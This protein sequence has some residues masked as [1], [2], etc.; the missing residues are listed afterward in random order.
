MF[1]S[2]EGRTRLKG[3]IVLIFDAALSGL[4][5]SSVAFAHY[6]VQT[7]ENGGHVTHHAAGQQ[8]WQNAQIYKGRSPNFQ[9]VWNATAL[10]VDIKS[11]LALGILGR[12]IHLSRRSVESFGHDNEMMNKFL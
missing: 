5:C 6:E 11:Q 8:L 3:T 4:A 9:A 12:E 1:R 10:A 7:A 2:Q